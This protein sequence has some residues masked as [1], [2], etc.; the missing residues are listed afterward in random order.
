MSYPILSD[1][2]D[3]SFFVECAPFLIQR[4]VPVKK[5]LHIGA[6]KCEEKKDYNAA[7]V[8]DSRIVWIEGNKDLCEENQKKG[9]PNVY[10]ALI[11][12]TDKEVSFHITNNFASSSI[13]PLYIHKYYYPHI[14]ETEV[15]KEKAITLQTFF[16]THS[17]DPSEFS[18]WSL[19]IQGAEL[20]ALKGAGDL[21]NHVDVIFLEIN[22]EKMYEGIPLSDTVIQFL[23]S[24]GFELTH[25]KIWRNC[26]G[27]SLFVR[28]KYLT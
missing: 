26:W 2:T 15:R 6:H 13:Y 17:L 7:G 11:A 1:W 27:D 8:D 20:D 14:V 23:S 9:I 19:D 3:D 12:D 24:K 21:I 28:R 18:F 22:Y 10:N 5:I 25:S 4:N 16:K